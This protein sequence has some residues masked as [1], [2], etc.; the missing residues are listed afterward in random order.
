MSYVFVGNGGSVRWRRAGLRRVTRRRCAAFFALRSAA[1][2][3]LLYRS[4]NRSDDCPAE[5]GY[6]IYAVVFEP[7]RAASQR[8]R[9]AAIMAARLRFADAGRAPPLRL[10]TRSQ[11]RIDQRAGDSAQRDRAKGRVPTRAA[12]AATQSAPAS[13]AASPSGVTPPDIPGRSGR[14]VRIETGGRRESM[15]SS[16]P[17]VSADAAANAPAKATANGTPPRAAGSAQSAATPPFAKTCQALR[18]A[19]A[20]VP[21]SGR[22]RSAP[23]FERIVDGRKNAKSTAA[24]GHP[25]LPKTIVPTAKAASAPPAVSARARY[26]STATSAAKSA[27]VASCV[28]PSRRSV[29]R[30]PRANRRSCSD[31]Q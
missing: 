23:I 7:A 22:L 3:S 17:H 15:P 4:D 21:D 16:V 26:A 6:E 27:A 5:R 2:A 31:R 13:V 28:T 18:A 29:R 12:T 19:G 10:Q 24:A 11:G 20:A 1:I 30:G 8:G 25:P 9:A 14:N